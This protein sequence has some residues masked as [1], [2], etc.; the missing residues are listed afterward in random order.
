MYPTQQQCKLCL[1]KFD[2]SVEDLLFY[3]KIEVP[4]PTLCPECRRRRRMTWRN[5][6]TFYNRTCDATGEN[7]I[8]LYAPEKDRKV[9]SVKYWWSD[10][11]DP[12]SYGRDFDFSR[13]FFEQFNELQRDVPLL[14]LMN[15]DGIGSS[16][17][18]YTQNEAY[19]KNSYMVSMA[20]KN[21]D[22]MYSY[23]VS[24]PQ[25]VEVVDSMDI[26]AST[27]IYE[28]IF[29]N[30]CYDCSFSSYSS[31]LVSCQFCYDCRN[32]QNCFMSVGLRGKQ[33]CFKNKQYSKEEYE[34]LVAAYALHTLSGQERAKKEW[35]TFKA[36]MPQRATYLVACENCSGDALLNSKN[37]HHVFTARAFTDVFAINK[38]AHL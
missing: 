9:Y 23:G 15:D 21:E 19:A 26:F 31:S 12:K 4:P 8:S 1:E 25:A 33:Y 28:S 7:I 14:A 2:I 17:C 5:D 22:C 37:A 36:S 35:E 30:Q 11:W 16:N 18:A 13:P 32:C 10:A 24:G 3:Q 20:W 6:F 27:R 29:L 38:Y 34:K